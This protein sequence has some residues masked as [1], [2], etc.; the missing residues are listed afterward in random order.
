M[1]SVC[2]SSN[3]GAARFARKHRVRRSL[4]GRFDNGF[5]VMVQFAIVLATFR[6]G[7]HLCRYV[8]GNSTNTHQSVVGVLDIDHC[9]WLVVFHSNVKGNI[10]I[11]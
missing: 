10:K 3:N 11:V 2:V 5:L 9:I 8:F 6:S 7:R 1:V 4:F